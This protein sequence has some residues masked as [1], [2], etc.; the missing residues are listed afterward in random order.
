MRFS[1][2]SFIKF[3]TPDI[4]ETV[5]MNRHVN[6]TF[7]TVSVVFVCTDTSYL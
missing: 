5:F 4:P 6:I 3:E 2:L 7:S 1:V